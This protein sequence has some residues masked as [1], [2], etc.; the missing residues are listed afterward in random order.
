MLAEDPIEEARQQWIAQGWDKAAPGLALIASLVRTQQIFVQRLEQ[1]LRPLGLSLARFEIL[2]QLL[3]SRNGSLALGR[4][5][6]RLQVAPGAITNAIDRLEQDGLV[7]RQSDAA[8][9]RVTI[10]SITRAG[11]TRGLK[12]AQIVNERVY[13]KMDLDPDYMHTVYEQLRVIREH[14]GDFHTDA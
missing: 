6:T 7:R 9:G 3:F 12:A 14:A 11:R 10:A 5:R 1:E 8:D 13:E 4:M 2:M